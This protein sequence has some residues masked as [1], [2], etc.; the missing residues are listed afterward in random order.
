MSLQIIKSGILDTIQDCGRYG[1]QHF[2]I[3][4]G[5]SMDQFSSQLSNALLGKPLNDPVIEI[6]FPS[7]KMFFEKETVL[8]ICGADLSPFINEQLIPIGQP[9][10]IGKGCVLEFKKNNYGARVYISILNGL[11]IEEWLNSFSTNLKAEAGGFYGKALKTGDRL[12]Y[13]CEIKFKGLQSGQTFKLLPWSTNKINHFSNNEIRFLEGAEWNLMTFD[14]VE[15][16]K[17]DE[18]SISKFSDRMGYRLIGGNLKTKKEESMISS[19]VSFGTIQLLPDGQMII[20]M[21]DHQTT[22]GYPR[23]ANVITTDL[24]KLAQKKPG[25]VIKFIRTNLKSA[26]EKLLMQKK[27]LIELQHACKIKIDRLLDVIL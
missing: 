7:P 15:K 23:I 19:A 10:F 3:N 22:G 4:T 9:V 20:L 1:F 6:H 12:N 26:E 16:F 13:K 2:G 8:C 11:Q 14:S 27:Y 18:F 5:G 17:N 25:D 21:A 24:P